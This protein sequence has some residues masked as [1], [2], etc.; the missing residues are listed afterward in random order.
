MEKVKNTPS[1]TKM[2]TR[3]VS[4][5][6]NTL[7]VKKILSEEESPKSYEERLKE[8]LEQ[9]IPQSR[10]YFPLNDDYDDDDDIYEPSQ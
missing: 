1:N 3:G 4:I 7:I 5:G 2:D 6:K 10:E 8:F 9:E